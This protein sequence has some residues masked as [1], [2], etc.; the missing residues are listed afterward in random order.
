MHLAMAANWHT[1]DP[2]EEPHYCEPTSEGVARWIE[3][4]LKYLADE[5]RF[6]AK[7]TQTLPPSS[8]DPAGL[9]ATG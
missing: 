2:G 1:E 4:C 7:K 3:G 5:L 9:D 6:L 8:G